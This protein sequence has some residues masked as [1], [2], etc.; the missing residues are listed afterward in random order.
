MSCVVPLFVSLLSISTT[1]RYPALDMSPER[2]K[3]QTLDAVA[4]QIDGLSADRP[5][6]LLFEDAV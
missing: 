5:M 4:S 1:G 2:Q 6:L 3:Q